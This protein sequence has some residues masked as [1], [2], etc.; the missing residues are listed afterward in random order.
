MSD[1][2][3]EKI[4]VFKLEFSKLL[5]FFGTFLVERNKQIMFM[6]ANAIFNYLSAT[7]QDETIFYLKELISLKVIRSKNV[8]VDFI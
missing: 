8:L 5:E 2:G 7:N 1:K 3:K 6:R 4:K